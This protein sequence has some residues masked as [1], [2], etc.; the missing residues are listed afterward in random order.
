MISD[1]FGRKR[2]L[3]LSA[4]LFLL[5]AIGAALPTSITQFAIARFIGGLG[6]GAAS[7]ISPL[8]IAEIAPAHIRG[9]LVS[10]NQMAIVTGI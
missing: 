1:H 5:S 6:I 4:G 8:Y 10:L 2:V 7:L 9:R 3:Y